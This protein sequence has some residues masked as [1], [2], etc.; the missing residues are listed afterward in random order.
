MRAAS[1]TA[2]ASAAS[3]IGT[4]SAP[5]TPTS[6]SSPA[7]ANRARP[8]KKSGSA[9]SLKFASA[10]GPPS[11]KAGGGSAKAAAAQQHEEENS[12]L[13]AEIV[14]QQAEIARQ[15][16][17]LGERSRQEAELRAENDKLRE[18]LETTLAEAAAAKGTAGARRKNAR[19]RDAANEI[20]S[21]MG[22]RR[23]RRKVNLVL[24]AVRGFADGARTFKFDRAA[25]ESAAM[26]RAATEAAAAEAAALKAALESPA[27][28]EELAALTSFDQCLAKVLA[29]G[30]I[31]LLRSAWL[32]ARP[33][34]FRVPMRQELTDLDRSGVTPSPLLSPAE[35]V[36]LLRRGTRAVAVLSHGWLSPNDPDPAGVRAH[37]V[38][39]A[40]E[41]S[42]HLEALFWEYALFCSASNPRTKPSHTS[43]ALPFVPK[44]FSFNP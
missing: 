39:R 17:D 3:D 15:Q 16:A 30:D 25:A 2:A 36:A 44:P 31:R 35:A 32:L 21:A 33:T 38:C 42:P 43:E 9:A 19:L 5:S 7:P 12:R 23:E 4:N 40:L 13:K 8:R 34:G 20:I 41:H 27:A 18:Q 28:T 11:V 26:E 29:R 14:R 22:V 24:V 1:I 10:A 6:G 37:V